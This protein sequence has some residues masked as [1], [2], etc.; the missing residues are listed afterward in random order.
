MK[1][2]GIIAEYNPFHHGHA[3]Q[4]ERI[5]ER[6]G[7]DTA[8]VIVMSGSFTQRGEPAIVDKWARTRMALAMGAS[9]VIEL[10][11]PY[12][13]ASAERF[14][15][16]GVRCLLATGVVGQ[17]AFGSE[18]GSLPAL[19]RIAAI[20]T[21]EPPLFK[22]VLREQLDRGRSFPAARQQAVQ[23]CLA[24]R[25]P[26]GLA[27]DGVDA[28]LLGS[29]NNILAIEYLK[30]LS[31]HGDGRIKPWT[32][33]REGQHYRGTDLDEPTGL[34]SATAIRRRVQTAGRNPAVLIQALANQ[35]PP[36]A[37]GILTEQ[38]ASGR[39]PVFHEN[40]APTILSLLSNETAERIDRIA[41]MEEGLGRRLMQ[42]AS[43]PA[44]GSADLLQDLLQAADTRRFPAT[45]INRALAALLA[46]V[47]REDLTL[48]DEAGGPQ[49]LRVLGFD[50]KG[51]YLLKL[52]RRF[53]TLP[54]LMKGSDF[55]ELESAAAV[56]MAAL[57]RLST[58]L[59]SYMAGLPAGAD[60]DTPVIMR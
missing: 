25:E 16:G 21:C 38:I 32:H 40:A 29:A 4:F 60:F 30:A 54:V 10:P 11:F 17:L 15:T 47:T 12:A 19:E 48:F 34:A 42:F 43:R 20:L 56:R 33:Q 23:A 35:M 59:W 14:A 44:K 50:R 53:S 45:R 3:L 58:D 36:A 2:I 5:R 52:M 57:D 22:S 28:S 26:D 18:S 1:T 24:A 41:G 6:F 31:R 55:L 51:R 27:A 49:Y 39:G 46:G 7:A 13:A 37:L 8:L 9:L